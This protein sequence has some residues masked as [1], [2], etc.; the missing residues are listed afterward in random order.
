[1]KTVIEIHYLPILLQTYLN[2][3]LTEF[4][5]E[6][7]LQILIRTPV[8]F[9]RERTAFPEILKDLLGKLQR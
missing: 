6:D 1:M 8:K 4:L 7:K 2:N 3:M 5:P 9:R